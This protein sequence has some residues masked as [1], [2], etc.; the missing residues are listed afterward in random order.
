MAQETKLA[1]G[2]GN[3]GEEGEKRLRSG[4]NDLDTQYQFL[5]F[6]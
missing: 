6:Q 1:K 4:T 2:S 5:A 3:E